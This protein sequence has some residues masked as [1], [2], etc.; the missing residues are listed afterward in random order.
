[1]TA[2]AMGALIDQ[3]LAWGLIER[4]ADPHDARAR[5]LRF[6]PLGL[7]WLAAFEDA[8]R[9]AQNEFR[10]DVGDAVATVVTLGLEAYAGAAADPAAPR[11][12]QR[13][14]SPRPSPAARRGPAKPLKR[15]AT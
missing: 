7:D 12:A 8:V 9:Q 2:Q 13:P 5:W 10:D 15:R 1:M 11:S 6:T 3:G 14:S 4:S